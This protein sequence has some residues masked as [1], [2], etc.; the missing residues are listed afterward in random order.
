MTTNW[1]PAPDI[2]LY[3]QLKDVFRAA[4]ESGEWAADGLIPTERELAAAY[5]VSKAPVRQALGQLV[6]EGLLD[7]RQGRGTWVLPRPAEWATISGVGLAGLIERH[8]KPHRAEV[9]RFTVE[10]A[11]PSI[12]VGLGCAA[13]TQIYRIELRRFAGDDPVALET[14]HVPRSVLPEL[15][16]D[17]LGGQESI[18]RLLR[19]AGHRN[20]HSH[21][22]LQ[23]VVLDRDEATALGRARGAP[24]LLLTNRAF[25]RADAVVVYSFVLLRG[26]F[27]RISITLPPRASSEITEMVRPDLVESAP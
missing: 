26:D 25:D 1:R 6:R 8:G 20:T 18:Y 16:R 24:A 14:L 10:P 17:M 11:A 7:R 9:R 23:A 27:F 12:A 3:S 13:G 5:G 4:I 15:R 22:H 21:Q 19:Q 2:P